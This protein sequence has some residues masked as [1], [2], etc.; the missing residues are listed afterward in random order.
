MKEISSETSMSLFDRN[1][2]VWSGLNLIIFLSSHQD[3]TMLLLRTSSA[4][5]S[6]SHFLSF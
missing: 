2:V 6:F 5:G 3:F 4:L 1:Y